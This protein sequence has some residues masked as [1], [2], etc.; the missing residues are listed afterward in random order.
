[1]QS[2]LTIDKGKAESVLLKMGLC[3]WKCR[4]S[5]ILKS[6]ILLDVPIIVKS[7]I[8]C[9]LE[10]QERLWSALAWLRNGDVL[11]RT[12]SSMLREPCVK[13]A[14][15]RSS[16][17]SKTRTTRNSIYILHRISENMGGRLC[18]ERRKIC[19]VYCFKTILGVTSLMYLESKDAS[20]N[21]S[22]SDWWPKYGSLK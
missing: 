7:R 13:S 11:L 1:M 4:Y 3:L 18:N 19:F 10:L 14:T 5:K 6:V 17:W 12:Y 20:S 16:Q 9:S 15:A 22:L 8:I 21:L 2:Y